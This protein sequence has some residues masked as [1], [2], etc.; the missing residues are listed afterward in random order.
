EKKVILDEYSA[1]VTMLTALSTHEQLCTVTVAMERLLTDPSGKNRE[2][3]ENVRE[4]LEDLFVK[5][6]TGSIMPETQS[7]FY[8]EI[9]PLDALCCINRMRGATFLSRKD[10]ANSV[11]NAAIPLVS[12]V[13]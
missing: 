7:W 5:G 13:L 8:E 2:V 12:V 4:F 11:G 3:L 1:D 10:P 9:R 6:K